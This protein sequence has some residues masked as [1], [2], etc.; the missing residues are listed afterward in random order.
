[1][2]KLFNN[3]HLII[4]L[5]LFISACEG[6]KQIPFQ[7]EALP[8]DSKLSGNILVGPSVLNDSKR[9]VWGATVIKGEDEKYHM[10]FSTWECGDSIPPFSDS[11]FC[12]RS[13]ATLFLIIR[14]GIINFKRSFSGAELWRAIVWLGTHKWFIIRT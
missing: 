12:I 7:V 11:W 13:L 5:L 4:L 2:M 9:F 10:I 3:Y 8:I 6:E 14:I 1:M